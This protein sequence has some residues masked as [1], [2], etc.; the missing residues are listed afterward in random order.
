MEYEGTSR[1]FVYDGGDGESQLLAD[2]VRYCDADQQFQFLA[3]RTAAERARFER[4][5]AGGGDQRAMRLPVVVLVR[6]D[7]RTGSVVERGVVSGE[8][9][10]TWL[11]SLVD[12]VLPLAP[13]L[14]PL[15]H[16]NLSPHT[17]RF[18][19][20]ALGGVPAA[21]PP[22]GHPPPA[23][24]TEAPAAAA[25]SAQGEAALP[26]TARRVSWNR[27]GAPGPAPTPARAPAADDHD[28]AESEAAEGYRIATR[29]VPQKR[30]GAV[31]ISDAMAQSK[32]RDATMSGGRKGS[33]G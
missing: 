31:N 7:P 28:V 29:P 5:G 4:F 32:V 14:A 22:T 1:V 18:V 30:S 10:E 20:A 2:L 11:R 33:R 12:S 27:Q 6:T 19:L 15:A 24:A 26:T 13:S 21:A 16:R 23:P 3:L 8:R 25:E 17:L 9:L